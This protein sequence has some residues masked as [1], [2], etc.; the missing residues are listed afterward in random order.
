MGGLN[1]WRRIRIEIVRCTNPKRIIATDLGKVNF[2]AGF[3]E[4]CRLVHFGKR[5]DSGEPC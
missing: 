1:I 3:R 4:Q 5:K 2:C